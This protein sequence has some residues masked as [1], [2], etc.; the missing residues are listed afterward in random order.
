MNFVELG[1]KPGMIEILNKNGITEPTEIQ[2]KSFQRV[3]EG[4]D[5]VGISKTGSGK[6]FA[7]GLPLLENVEPRKGLQVLVMVPT[8]ELAVQITKELSKFSAQ[9]KC[10]ISAI[11]GG[12]S[13]EPQVRD[14]AHS[15]IIVGTPG[16]LLDHLNRRN[17][18]LSKLKAVVLDEADKMVEMGFIEDITS[19]LDYTPQYRQ[20]LLFGATI[21]REIEQL[22][23]HYMHDPTIVEVETQVNEDFLQQFY[24]NVQQHEKF[25]L[26]VHLLKKEN[27]KRVMVFCSSCKTVDIVTKNLRRQNF[28]VESL[29]GQLRQN[30]RLKIIDDFNRGKLDILVA[31]PVA[32]RGLDIKFVTHIFNY[33]LS[34]DP[35]E[36]VHRVGRTARAGEHGK[37]I[38]LLSSK[39]FATFGEIL[40]R[41]PITVNEMPEEN[42]AKVPFDAGR[43][44]HDNRGSNNFH[45]ASV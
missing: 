33:D 9:C 12:V 27:Y 41:Y 24:Y 25:S 28:V 8:R 19:I 44:N 23:K 38:T 31:S 21:S 37:A 30:R 13:L 45:R 1:L 10:Y 6:T 36:Y 22:K 26:L 16:R 32:A 34:Q 20:M 2:Q 4:K 5:L 11:F 15:E 43:N 40:R 35:Q 3:K 18:N 29:H 42:F 14:L 39:D 17:L 7:F